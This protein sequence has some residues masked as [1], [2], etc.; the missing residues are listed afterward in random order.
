MNRE[1]NRLTDYQIK[2][3]QKAQ[4]GNLNARK[5]Y[6]KLCKEQSIIHNEV[7]AEIKKSQGC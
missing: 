6:T 4:S 7:K 3:K 1:L 5:E 2:L